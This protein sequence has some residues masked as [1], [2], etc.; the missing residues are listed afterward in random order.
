M[1]L[2]LLVGDQRRL[3]LLLL[4]LIGERCVDHF[5]QYGEEDEYD[6]ED[7]REVYFLLDWL[8]CQFCFQ[9]PLKKKNRVLYG[10][11]KTTKFKIHMLSSVLR[12]F[13]AGPRGQAFSGADDYFD[14]WL[15]DLTKG[16]HDADDPFGEREEGLRF[17]NTVLKILDGIWLD[18]EGEAILDAASNAESAEVFI[19]FLDDTSSDAG[20]SVLHVGSESDSEREAE[21]T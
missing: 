19:L 12:I 4:S 16:D 11:S 8:S 20:S 1:L 17:E 6:I 13:F 7:L 3:V 21:L 15:F 2:T 5:Y 9:R 18:S 10:L 14:L